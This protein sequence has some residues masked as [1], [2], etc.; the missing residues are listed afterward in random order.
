MPVPL[1][2]KQ[3]Y[4]DL[5]SADAYPPCYKIVPE[6]PNFMV[7][8]WL[9]AL[10]AE[11]LEQRTIA[12]S[13]R[14]KACNGD[15]EATYFV[16]LARNFGFGINGDAFEQWAKTIPFHAVDHHRDDLFQIETIFMGQAGLLQANALPKQHS[17]KAV[18]DEYFLH[19]QREYKY[20]AHKFSLTPI[21]GHLWHFLRLRPQNFPYIRIA[22]LAQLYYNRRAGLAE[23]IDCTTIKEVAELLE[24]QVT[25]YWE[26]HYTFGGNDNK[27]SEKYLSKTSTELIIINTIVPFLFAYGQYKMSEKLCNRAFAFLE[28]LKAENNHIV[29]MWKEVGLTVKTA[30]DSQA[31][32][33]LKK[34][35]CDRKECL[36]CRIG[37]EYLKERK[38]KQ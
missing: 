18:T 37:Y 28:T 12:I 15:W 31:L 14:L 20:L 13:E 34:D 4:K 10:Q 8:S 6:L 32:I 3:H 19:L 23:M 11:R 27:Q 16:S 21:D 17:D 36:R 22:Q 2:V 5:L 25:T 26:T 9:S 33:Q 38:Q 1:S 30:G 24:T 29:R 7:H 35:Y